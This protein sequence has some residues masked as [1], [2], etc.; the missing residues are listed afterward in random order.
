MSFLTQLNDSNSASSRA[1]KLIKTNTTD[2]VPFI[3][4]NNS[5]ALNH[6]R[7]SKTKIF[8]NLFNN[9]HL[10]KQQ[11]VDT[12][13]STIPLL[14]TNT[15]TTIT[16]TKSLSLKKMSAENLIPKF[17]RHNNMSIKN[18]QKQ[19]PILTAL[20][21]QSEDS[22]RACHRRRQRAIRR[23]LMLATMQLLLNL[24]NYVLQ[25]VD[26]FTMLRQTSRQFAVFYLY[27]DAIFYLFYLSQYP[28]IA[29]YVRWFHNNM[30]L[31]KSTPGS[32]NYSRSFKT[33]SLKQSFKNFFNIQKLYNV[34]NHLI[35]QNSN[36]STNIS[37]NISELDHKQQNTCFRQRN[38]SCSLLTRKPKLTRD[39]VKSEKCIIKTSN[40][41]PKSPQK[42][43]VNKLSNTLHV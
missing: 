36:T 33:N 9:S 10:S 41:L 22:L 17:F 37:N 16:M 30:G 19:V 2:N 34:S 11:N 43:S 27:A 29:V 35:N 25:L 15:T 26:E 31:A 12:I 42:N 13:S 38:L 39:S 4:S 24:P 40:T 3:Q 8:G 20:K 18:G 6:K 7:P 14:K 1:S 21:I 32:Q 28:M 5:D 23:C